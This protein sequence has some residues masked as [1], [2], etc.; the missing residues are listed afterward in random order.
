MKDGAPVPSQMR[1]FLINRSSIA[2]SSLPMSVRYSAFTTWAGQAR[3][4]TR[5]CHSLIFPSGPMTTPTRAAP[6]AGSTL[7]P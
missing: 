7:A 1:A 2:G 4:S 5:S 6:L 3:A